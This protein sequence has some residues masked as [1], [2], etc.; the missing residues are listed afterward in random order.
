MFGHTDGRTNP[1]VG[2]APHHKNTLFL[3]WLLFQILLQTM[4][5]DNT[6]NR[7]N[8]SNGRQYS[9]ESSSGSNSGSSKAYF[10]RTIIPFLFLQFSVGLCASLQA[11]FYPI[12][13][14][15]KGATASQFGAV[16]GII[17][18]SLFIFGKSGI[19]HFNMETV[20]WIPTP[21]QTH[22]VLMC[23]LK[24]LV[25]WNR[26]INFKNSKGWTF[27]LVPFPLFGHTVRDLQNNSG[28][29]QMNTYPISSY[30]NL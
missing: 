22:W 28:V 11:T 19:L 15:L 14:G 3:R 16:F 23:H 21:P 30:Y 29:K 25:F 5:G 27:A 1:H 6:E 4:G 8:G 10:I 24:M 9:D 26:L 17:H 13:A 20:Q 12:E 7:S 18:L 2:A